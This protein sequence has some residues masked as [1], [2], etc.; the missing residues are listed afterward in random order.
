MFQSRRVDDAARDS[1]P[2]QVHGAGFALLLVA[3]NNIHI[4]AQARVYC[5]AVLKR[6][7]YELGILHIQGQGGVGK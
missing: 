1:V 3:G 4:Y 5:M 2:R 6:E 7:V